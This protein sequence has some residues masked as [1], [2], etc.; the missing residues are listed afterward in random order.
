M[1]EEIGTLLERSGI[2]LHETA[3]EPSD[4]WS[5]RSPSRLNHRDDVKFISRQQET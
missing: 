1:F 5:N 2:V 4:T 3:V